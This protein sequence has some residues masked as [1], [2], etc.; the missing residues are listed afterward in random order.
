M[1]REQVPGRHPGAQSSTESP[2]VQPTAPGKRTLTEGLVV[3]RRE[4]AAEPA[5]SGTRAPAPA[6]LPVSASGGPRPTLEMLFGAQRD[7]TAAPAEDP[8]QAHAAATP[9]PINPTG[10]RASVQAKMER[11]FQT[12]FSSVRIHEQSSLATGLGAIAAAKGD[13]VHFAPGAYHPDTPSGQE[14]LGHELAHVMQ[15]R[16]GRVATAQ[17]KGDQSVGGTTLN[18]DHALER[19]ADEMGARAARG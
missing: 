1:P 6:P 15:Q 7:A 9:D 10:M 2:H 14:V 12:D 16:A 19:E 18:V 4:A 8:A 5:G 3:Q 17:A 13:E 11:S